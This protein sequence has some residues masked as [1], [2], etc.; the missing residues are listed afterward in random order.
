CGGDAAPAYAAAAHRG[1][2]AGGRRPRRV[3]GEARDEVDAEE[4]GPAGGEE[5]RGQVDG[6]EG[7]GQAGQ[8]GSG[9]VDGE[10]GGDQAGEEGR[11]QVDGEED[12]GQ[13]DGEEGHRQV[14]AEEGGDQVD[15]E[16]D[17]DQAG[18]EEDR[19]QVDGAQDGGQGDREEDHGQDG[20]EE[21]RGAR[22][23]LEDRRRAPR[24]RLNP[25]P[26]RRKDGITGRAHPLRRVPSRG[27]R[28][29]HSRRSGVGSSERRKDGGGARAR[30][31]PAW[32]RRRL[33]RRGRFHAGPRDPARRA[34]RA[35]GRADGGLSLVA[36]PRV[37]SRARPRAHHRRRAPPGGNRRAAPRRVHAQRPRPLLPL[38]DRAVRG[39]S[40]GGFLPWGLG[41]ARRLQ[42]RKSVV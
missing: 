18:G 35:G 40:A 17:H 6:E 42:D 32:G 26:A 22:G 11:D 7:G 3:A 30:P 25:G 27:G 14:D 38:Q 31:R 1:R 24:H 36:S 16:E 10:E 8:E 23:R 20:A 4:G 5:G 19:G 33:L 15:G 21:D 37:G 28:A 34:G 2:N 41:G 29:S 39:L 9:E 12:G 13:A